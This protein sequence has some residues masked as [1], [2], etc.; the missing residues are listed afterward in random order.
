MAQKAAKQTAKR[1]TAVLNRTHLI[2][3]A[4][5]AWFLI[6]RY[7]LGLH[8]SASIVLY[9]LLSVPA[10]SIELWLE[11]IGRPTHVSDTGELRRSGEDLEAKGLT[12][13]LWDVLYWSW[14]CIA[15]A[16]LLGGWTWWLWAVIPLYSVW[17]AYSMFGNLR[18]GIMGMSAQGNTVTEAQGGSNR[19]RKMEK[20][21]GLKTTYR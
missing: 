12:E 2:T 6:L 8:R 20:R 17:L 11:R 5:H 3:A 15:L 7:L 9:V 1:N 10:L 19:Q 16:P 14:A 18:H 21:G 4:V 13:Y